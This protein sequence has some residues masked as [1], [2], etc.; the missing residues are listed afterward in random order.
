MVRRRA[1][2]HRALQQQV[3]LLAHPVLGDEL[4]QP[5]RAARVASASRSASLTYAETS[6]SVSRIVPSRGHR[7]A[8][9]Q[10]DGL[11]EQDRHAAGSRRRVGSATAATAW[12]ACPA[13]Q[14]S[15]TSAWRTWSGQ[16]PRGHRPRQRRRRRSAPGRSGRAAPA[17]AARRP[18][19]RCPGTRVRA[20]V[21]PL[22]IALRTASGVCTAS[23]AWAS[24]GPTP[25]AV[26]SSSNSAWRR[27]RRSRR[28][29]ASPPARSGWSRAG[30]PRRPAARRG[31][32]G[33][34]ARRGR[35]RRPRSR[36]RPDAIAA[37]RAAHAGD[38]RRSSS[39]CPV[40]PRRPDLGPGAAAPHVADG[41][42]QRVGGVRRL[43]RLGQ[44]AAAGSPS[45]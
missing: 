16:L 14:P 12:S 27:R 39:S 3:E 23:T 17:P 24:R 13:V 2:P 22:A 19:C 35:P 15:P 5:P 37:T 29:S 9:Q 26:W 18:S 33:R 25:L 43:G 1:P 40:A 10:S 41:Q 30:P 32:P 44:L 42:R 38:H 4:G 11:L 28:G 7:V 6:P 45:R 34:S 36:R 20:A 21:S 8:A 31:C